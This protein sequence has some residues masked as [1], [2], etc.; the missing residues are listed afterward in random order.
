MGNM[1]MYVNVG[2][3]GRPEGQWEISALLDEAH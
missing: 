1:Q 3:T 2:Q